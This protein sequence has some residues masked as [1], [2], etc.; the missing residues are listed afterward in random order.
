MCYSRGLLTPFNPNP[1]GLAVTIDRPWS[2][3]ALS[4][5][6]SEFLMFWLINFPTFIWL[7]VATVT[8]SLLGSNMFSR[9]TPLLWV[10][11]SMLWWPPF[12]VHL[13]LPTS[14]AP[15]RLFHDPHRGQRS[16]WEHVGLLSSP[17]LFSSLNAQQ[18][19][20]SLPQGS[21][22]IIHMTEEAIWPSLNNS[23][24]QYSAKVLWN[25]FDMPGTM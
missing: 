18:Q 14:F 20:L 15:W 16:I 2:L 12:P 1:L 3:R 22:W 4:A 19:L 5:F 23:S 25:I 21:C 9:L 17:T 11:P 13:S 24:V 6:L 7:V 8:A 10:S